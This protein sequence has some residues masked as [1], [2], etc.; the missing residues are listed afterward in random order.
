MP[1]VSTFACVS[2]LT[3]LG[4]I[5]TSGYHSKERILEGLYI[6]HTSSSIVGL[7][8][9][10]I[11]L[12][13]SYSMKLLTWTS[14]N[15]SFTNR[16]IVNL[17]GCRWRIKIPLL[18]LGGFSIMNGINVDNFTSSK[19]IVI[20]NFDALLPFM[21]IFIGICYGSRNRPIIS[22]I[23]MLTPLTQYLSIYS[24]GGHQKSIDKGWINARILSTS[25]ISKF[26]MQPIF[27]YLGFASLVF[28]MYYV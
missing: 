19:N 18:I 25:F 21:C 3:L 11:A 23:I 16:S 20:D 9:L 28:M 4:F 12:T 1:L 5:F 10:G 14:V 17:G 22:G 7:F 2:N 24:M 26:L 8:L 15:G 13:T 27:L 6:E